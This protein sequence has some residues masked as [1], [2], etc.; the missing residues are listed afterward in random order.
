MRALLFALFISMSLFSTKSQATPS[1][2][3]RA[4]PA[5]TLDRPVAKE[6]MRICN[7]PNDLI[8]AAKA[9]ISRYFKTDM[10]NSALF[11]KFL[12][13][14]P[15]HEDFIACIICK[16]GKPNDPYWERDFIRMCDERDASFYLADEPT[17]DE[18]TAFL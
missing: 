16:S 10:Y 6:L 7:K 5:Y 2:H 12:W 13:L 17:A 4:I 11:D 14:H 8:P 1:N 15:E 18:D 9:L 3:L